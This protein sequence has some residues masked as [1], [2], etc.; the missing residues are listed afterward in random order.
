MKFVQTLLIA[1][2]LC[3][4]YFMSPSVS[5]QQTFKDVSTKHGN[6]VDIEW[7]VSKGLLKGYSDNTFRPSNYLTES[8]FAKIFTRYASPATLQDVEAAEENPTVYNYFTKQGI[9]LPGHTTKSAINKQFTRIQVAKVFYHYYEGTAAPSNTV[10]IDWMY[11]KGLTTGKGVSSDKY[12]DFGSNDP[13]KRAHISAFFNRFDKVLNSE[14]LN[15][16]QI[17][18]KII[19]EEL[20]TNLELIQFDRINLTAAAQDEY[21]IYLRD[22]HASLVDLAQNTFIVAAYDSSLNQVK[23]LKKWSDISEYSFLERVAMNTNEQMIIW[24]NVGS[25]LQLAL[26]VVA[27]NAAGTIQATPITKVYKNGSFTVNGSSLLIEDDIYRL[28]NGKLQ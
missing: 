19:A 6:Y 16:Q 25:D 28:V 18:D 10:A 15:E 9:P 14:P 2:L 3:S 1:I 26:T 20:G 5:A 7:A 23:V 27:A 22:K 4:S 11:A 24:A 17:V 13:L 8:Q 12:K 21:F